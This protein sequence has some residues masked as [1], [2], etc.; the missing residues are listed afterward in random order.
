MCLLVM[1]TRTHAGLGKLKDL[2]AKGGLTVRDSSINKTKPNDA[3]DPTTS[4]RKFWP[5]RS[6]GPH[7]SCVHDFQTPKRASGL[8]GKSN[9][10]QRRE[11]ESSEST[12]KAL[13]TA[14]SEALEKYADD[15]RGWQSDGIVHAILGKKNEW[16]E[17]SGERS[18]SAS[19]C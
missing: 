6:N 13:T 9:T 12:L 17:P 19:D 11:R 18:G 5:L 1:C 8:I 10:Q 3:K 16:R 14:N 4:R 7:T 15:V 2:I